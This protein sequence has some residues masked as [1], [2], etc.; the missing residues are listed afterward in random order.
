M[1]V[2]VYPHSA[3]IGGSQLNALELAA[4]IR[5]AGHDVLLVSQPG[6]LT[7]LADGIGLECIRLA[8]G[9]R[10]ISP[11]ALRHLNQMVRDRRI[12][13][14]HGYEWPTAMALYLGPHCALQ[15]PAICTVMSMAIAPF[16]PREMPLIVGTRQLTRLAQA[17]GFKAVTLLEPP[18]DTDAN[19]PHC[20]GSAFRREHGIL[21]GSKLAVVVGRLAR[22][23][24]LEGLLSACDAIAAMAANGDPVEL[25][26]VG[27]GSER[28]LVEQRAASAN[29][30][31]GR[32][33]VHLAGSMQDPRG[34]YAAADVIL[35]MGGSALRG[36]AFAKPLIVQGERGFWRLCEP[37][38]LAQFEDGGWYGL[39][40]VSQPLSENGLLSASKRLEVELKPIVYDEPRRAA[41]AAFG[42]RLVLER[43]SLRRAVA[44]QEQLYLDA[45]AAKHQP[46]LGR[47]VSPIV[48]LL[49]HKVKRRLKRWRGNCPTDDFNAVARQPA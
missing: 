30:R 36:M 45:I 3:E 20:D 17:K 8:P 18:V 29:A 21:P 15:R 19:G 7:E 14:V 47:F 5:D 35:G 38:S 46:G 28:A 44:L 34:A 9:S 33:V 49:N 4:G 22:E 31:A 43:F 23:L 48:G 2:L 32:R 26:I 16:L 11:A 25:A 37:A 40:D 12:D 24:K 6:P 1:K 39:G 27:D 10:A 13:I 41:L 42:R